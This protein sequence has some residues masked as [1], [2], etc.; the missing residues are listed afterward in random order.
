MIRWAW[1]LFRREWRQQLLILLLVVVAVAAVVVGAAVAV[2][3]PPPANAGF[4]TAQDMATFTNAGKQPSDLHSVDA[5]IAALEHRF[6]TVQVI[7]NE[8]FNVPGSTQTYQL[9]SQDPHGPYGGPML[10]LLSG[11]Y[12]TGPN[13]IALTPGLASEL[14]LRV[15]DTWPQGGKTVV[16]IVQNPQSLL[17]EFALVPPR[18]GDATRPRWTSSSTHRAWTRAVS[19]PTSRRRRPSPTT[20]RSTPTTIVL[21]LATVGM[22]LIALVSI[23]GFT[24]LA[25]RR[26]RALG[27]LESM[28]ATD[29]NVRLVMRA[30]G[31]I[32]GVV[33]ALVGFALGLAAWLAYR[34]HNEQSAHHLIPMFALPWTVIVVAMVLAVVAT[35]F[36][37]GHP[38]RAITRVPVVSALAGRPAPP[39]AD[40]PLFRSRRDRARRRVL[41]SSPLSGA[42]HQG[43]GVIWLIPGFVALIAGIILVSPF[44]LALLAR[45]GR[46]A[47]IAV[48][49]ALPRPVAVPGP[50]RLGPLGHQRRRTDRGGHLRRRRRSLQQRLRLRR[51]EHGVERARRVQPD[52][53]DRQRPR[54]PTR[55]PTPN[56][57]SQEASVHS[58]APAVGAT[59]VVELDNPAPRRPAEPQ[60]VGP[61]V[62]RSDL[63]GDAGAAAGLR[64]QPVVH[65]F[66]RRHPQ[67]AP[68]ALGLGRAADLG[69]RREGRR[70]PGRPRLRP[71]RRRVPVRETRTPA[72]RVR[73][74]PTP[75]SK[76][77]ASCPRARTHRTR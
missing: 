72:L 14:N 34:P 46:K 40:P 32:V 56:I 53:P 51:P 21:A 75:S 52:W 64:H 55:R 62:G 28:G 30:N 69:G 26:L 33:G 73:A 25:Q 63:R 7:E 36:A 57:Q 9:R 19:G 6:G 3:T 65:S 66:Q 12:P 8:T 68:R 37:A 49:L 15:G 59:D 77:R 50:V 29:R 41:S 60:R 45:V 48:R 17:D 20:T 13:Q 11:H 43:S 74:S 10:Q 24:V 5:Q 38:A 42:G 35:F 23:G 27:M 22:L 58:I 2:N 76:K 67:L 70:R 16:G 1:R 31:V 71:G 39:R 47:P 54:I 4:G 61:A 18:A 44:F